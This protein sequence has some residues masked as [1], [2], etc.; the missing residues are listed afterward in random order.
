[1][2]TTKTERKT[3]LK[4]AGRIAVICIPVVAIVLI[5]AAVLSTTVFFR[6]KNF[7]IEGSKR[8][9]TAQILEASGLK[10]G[11]NMFVS[12]IDK[13]SEAIKTKLPYIEE[14]TIKRKLPNSMII[15]VKESKEVYGLNA[16]NSWYVVNANGKILEILGRTEPKDT[17]LSVWTAAIY[18]PEIGKTISYTDS[19][20]DKDDKKEESAKENNPFEL[21]KKILKAINKTELKGKIKIISLIDTNNIRAEYDGRI[22]L[23]F[24]D[25]KDIDEK[26]KFAAGALANEDKLDAQQKGSMDLT[27]LHQA[28]FYP[29]KNGKQK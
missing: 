13:A 9:S 1:M 28:H 17:T 5:I 6:V 25:I 29:E 26:L 14:V 3:H 7:D 2:E 10:E 27:V 16:A 22:R 15:T 23:E 21:F 8:Y 4:K 18:N 20:A 19:K 11:K 12:N 24:G